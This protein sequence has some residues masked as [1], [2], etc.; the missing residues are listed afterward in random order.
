MAVVGS[1]GTLPDS[2][3]R[4]AL[5]DA[6]ALTHGADDG[7]IKSIV[8][9]SEVGGVAVGGEEEGEGSGSVGCNG[10]GEKSGER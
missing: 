10:E 4:A 5:R 3:Q 1:E 2:Q 7:G 6:G 9:G 8:E